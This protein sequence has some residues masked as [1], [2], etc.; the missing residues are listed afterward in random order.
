M[1]I[2]TEKYLDATTTAKMLGVTTR[3]V[4]ALVKANRLGETVLIG[5][6]RL[7]PRERVLS[8]ERLRPGAKKKSE[9]KELI[10]EALQENVAEGKPKRSRRISRTE[11]PHPTVDNQ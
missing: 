3:R 7:I 1:I 5:H 10:T 8:F 11:K 9:N 6:T 2:D 4:S